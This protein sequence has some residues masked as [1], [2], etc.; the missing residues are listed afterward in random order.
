M[1][2]LAKTSTTEVDTL[3]LQIDRCQKR[4]ASAKARVT[5]A[6]CERRTRLA[7]AFGAEN[8][9]A[10]LDIARLSAE[11][12]AA[13]AEALDCSTVLRELET[14]LVS[15]R[16][17]LSSAQQDEALG[18]F[19]QFESDANGKSAAVATTARE[20]GKAVSALLSAVDASLLTANRAGCNLPATEISKSVRALIRDCICQHVPGL[21]PFTP[22]ENV[23]LGQNLKE[24]LGEFAV[25]AQRSLEHER[26]REYARGSETEEPDGIRIRIT[27]AFFVGGL[28]TRKGDLLRFPREISYGAVANGW[29]VLAEPLPDDA[30]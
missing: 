29:A 9:Q 30:A 18:S 25:K 3:A 17:E 7:A 14:Q 12:S 4:I 21:F 11:A 15:K 22:K 24:L 20:L 26:T 2:D 27:K 13:A 1:S 6:E 10:Q 23:T 16:A 28:P 19:A 8:P 5:A